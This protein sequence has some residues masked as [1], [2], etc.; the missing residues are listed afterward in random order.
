MTCGADNIM[1]RHLLSAVRTYHRSSS[2]DPG[3]IPSKYSVIPHNTDE[4]LL[5]YPEKD[6]RLPIPLVNFFTQHQGILGNTV[7]P[8]LPPTSHVVARTS[9]I[10]PVKLTAEGLDC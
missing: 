9:P 4:A 8:V 2:V 6:L 10:L 1:I 3:A 7:Q 5:P